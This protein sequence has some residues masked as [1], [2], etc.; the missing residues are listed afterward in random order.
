[1]R[2]DNLS[3][4]SPDVSTVVESAIPTAAAADKASLKTSLVALARGGPSRQGRVTFS[5]AKTQSY[6]LGAKTSS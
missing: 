4:L 2:D 3:S 5:T 6:T 1:M